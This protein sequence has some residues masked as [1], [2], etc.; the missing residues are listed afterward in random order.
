[1]VGAVH[2]L[3]QMVDSFCGGDNPNVVSERNGSLC[4]RECRRAIVGLTSDVCRAVQ[5]DDSGAR[6]DDNGIIGKS[7]GEGKRGGGS[8]VG[9][10][11]CTVLLPSILF[12]LASSGALATVCLLLLVLASLLLLWQPVTPL[13]LLLELGVP[14]VVLDGADFVHV[15]AQLILPGLV[16]LPS[17]EHHSLY[18]G[19]GGKG[20][21]LLLLFFALHRGGCYLGGRTHVEY[22]C[23][24]IHVP[25]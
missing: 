18:I 8:L 17:N 13:L 2:D 24:D 21:F 14:R 4:L 15:V 11:I 3:V 5:V 19:E 6:G 25:W 1:M 20:V 9:V 22:L 23:E 16:L 7:G 12:H 10:C